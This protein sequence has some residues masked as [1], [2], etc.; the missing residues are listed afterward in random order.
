NGSRRSPTASSPTRGEEHAVTDTLDT[1]NPSADPRGA[2]STGAPA[3]PAARRTSDWILRDARVDSGAPTAVEREVRALPAIELSG[4][5][6]WLTGE[7]LVDQGVEV[8]MPNLPRNL[9]LPDV[10]PTPFR[11]RV[12]V[13]GPSTVRVVIG[14][15]GG[16]VF[17]EPATWLGIVTRPE[18]APSM[19]EFHID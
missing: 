5:P 4:T 14:P 13:V 2:P 12:E 1:S 3:P 8:A 17:T 19:A 16:R 6:G 7:P 18:I 11:C 9:P 10:E 15:A